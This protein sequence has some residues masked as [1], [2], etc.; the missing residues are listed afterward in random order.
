MNI[1]HISFTT[2]PSSP[3]ISFRNEIHS[4]SGCSEGGETIPFPSSHCHLLRSHDFRLAAS[5]CNFLP[6]FASP[7]S[8][9]SR[10]LSS[11]LP[12]PY[13]RTFWC[14]L[15]KAAVSRR[16]AELCTHPS[17]QKCHSQKTFSSENLFSRPPVPT[18]ISNPVSAARFSGFK[19]DGIASSIIVMRFFRIPVQ[20]VC[21]MNLC[22]RF[23][24]NDVR[25]CKETLPF[26]PKFPSHTPSSATSTGRN[27]NKLYS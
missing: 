18:Q 6:F 10:S 9:S 23:T 13:Y 14:S 3:Q 11:F 24:S 16:Q 4:V 20:D 17:L 1:E 22:R 19:S 7:S 27:R 21:G 8:L 12:S 2:T 15:D 5:S 26:T 25:P